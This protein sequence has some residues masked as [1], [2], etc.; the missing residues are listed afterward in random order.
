MSELTIATFISNTEKYNNNFF[1][2][3]TLLGKK[4]NIDTIK[5]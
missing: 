3:C 2:F 5:L 4:I 1:D